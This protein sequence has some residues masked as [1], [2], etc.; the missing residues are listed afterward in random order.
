MTQL[1]TLHKFVHRVCLI[2]VLYV[3]RRYLG[4]YLLCKHTAE[5]ID[6]LSVGKYLRS[7]LPRSSICRLGVSAGVCDTS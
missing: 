7:I 4:T 5:P 6:F 3:T 2:G 1:F